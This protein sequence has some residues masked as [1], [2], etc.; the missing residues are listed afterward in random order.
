LFVFEGQEK[1]DLSPQP[2]VAAANWK[3]VKATRA[4]IV[5]DFIII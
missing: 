4:E 1:D 3:P 5:D 2:P